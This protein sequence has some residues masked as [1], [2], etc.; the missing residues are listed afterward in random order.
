MSSFIGVLGENTSRPIGT[1]GESVSEFEFVQSVEDL[2]VEV[3]NALH[4]YRRFQGRAEDLIG[5]SNPHL[6]GRAAVYA[7]LAAN[8]LTEATY[9]RDNLANIREMTY[10]CIMLNQGEDQEDA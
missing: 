9:Q 3:L 7:Q 2:S 10:G 8:K 5:R 4:E 1:K 6:Q